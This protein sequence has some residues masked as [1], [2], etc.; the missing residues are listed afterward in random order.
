MGAQLFSSGPI[1]RGLTVFRTLLRRL[2][3]PQVVV[4]AAVVATAVAGGIVGVARVAPQDDALVRGL[5]PLLWA[6]AAALL[7]GIA[8]AALI[9]RWAA[10]RQV[11]DVS[12][13]FLDVLPPA[14]AAN[15]SRLARADQDSVL[16]DIARTFSEL[17]DEAS[18]DQ[19]QL[20]TIISSMSDGLIAMDHQQRILITNAAA[21]E[22]MAFRTPD[23]RG[24]QIWEVVPLEGVLKGV[25]EVSLTGQRKTVP[26]GPVN[27]RYLEVTI[28]RLP[29]RPAGFIIVAHDITEARRYEELRKEFVANVSHELRT[30]LS[31]IKGYVETLRDGA[32]DDRE[33][34][35]QY[36]ATLER[37]TEQLTNLVDDLLS[38]S[39]LDS[40]PA[41]VPSPRPV[42]LGRVVARVAELMRPAAEKKGHKL[43][44]D[45]GDGVHPVVGNAE[46]LERAI[47]NL[48]ENAIKYTKEDGLI[49]VTVGG[50]Q[51]HSTVEVA[52]NGIGI[53]AEDLPRIFERFYRAER[54]RS[55]EMGGTGLGL[56]IVKHIVQA[57]QGTIDVQSTP[58]QG[59]TFRLTFPAAP[60]AEEDA[61]AVSPAVA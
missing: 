36:L 25:T 48:V 8:A 51:D 20:L 18:K 11:G 26:V 13:L 6:A 22:L 54:S 56:S 42:Q 1:H 55:R 4:I 7:G 38:L 28:T 35:V 37:H 27:N 46:Y 16:Y 24:K 59:S 44:V 30:P 33:R 39:R 12:S 45:L 53:A 3:V 43:V 23:A 52:D 58:G 47:G 2:L 10:R 40:A 21:H 61:S 5:V 57:H 31:V 17:M 9:L 60:P 34:A 15:S 19:A 32:I 50:D 29:L 49:R 41:A 14:Q